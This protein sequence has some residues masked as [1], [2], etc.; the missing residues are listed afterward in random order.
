[1]REVLT[2][3]KFAFRLR[4]RN[5]PLDGLLTQVCNHSSAFCEVPRSHVLR[6]SAS[7]ASSHVTVGKSASSASKVGRQDKIR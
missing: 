5:L 4:N 3:M 6:I 2:R 1:M 7:D